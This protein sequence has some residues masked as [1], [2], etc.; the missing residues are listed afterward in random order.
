MQRVWRHPACSPLKPVMH[1][2]CGFREAVRESMPVSC[3]RVSEVRLS[4]T[5]HACNKDAG[6]WM[7][8]HTSHGHWQIG[9]RS[10]GGQLRV[11][12]RFPICSHGHR[13]PARKG[14]TRNGAFCLHTI[15]IVDQDMVA[16]AAR[17]VDS[18]NRSIGSTRPRAPTIRN[19]H[20]AM[21]YLVQFNPMMNP[22]E[23][24]SALG[25]GGAR[26]R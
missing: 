14:H 25:A 20:R 26:V 17:I 9:R 11:G 1:E 19:L 22:I 10:E 24:L 18:R 3:D 8:A 5:H 16:F 23:L 7:A 2:V 12:T 15:K 4:Q 13:Q 6:I 21:Q